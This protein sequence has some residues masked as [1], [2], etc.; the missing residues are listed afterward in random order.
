V[1]LLL[2]LFSEKSESAASTSC[3]LTEKQ[4]EHILHPVLVLVRGGEITIPIENGSLP[5]ECTEKVSQLTIALVQL[6]R[7]KRIIHPDEEEDKAFLE[8]RYN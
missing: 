3:H 1:F 6:E 4:V 8:T 7:C 2:A 5:S